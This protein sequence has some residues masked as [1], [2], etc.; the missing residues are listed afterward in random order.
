MS[1]LFCINR[2]I[3]LSAESFPWLKSSP[4]IKLLAA[5]CRGVLPCSSVAL[6]LI[7]PFSNMYTPIH[8]AVLKY[9]ISFLHFILVGHESSSLNPDVEV[10]LNIEANG[11]TLELA[12][13]RDNE[14]MVSLLA[15]R[16]IL[17]GVMR[18]S[19]L[20]LQIVLEVHIRALRALSL[21]SARNLFDIN[22]IYEEGDTVLHMAARSRNTDL[23][24]VLLNLGA[25]PDTRNEAGKTALD[26]MLDRP[27][28]NRSDEDKEIIRL[29]EETLETELATSPC[30]D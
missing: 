20:L 7:S 3:N 21:E 18:R 30:P 9:N 6:A 25:R 8:R 24:K 29:L 13:Q 15:P 2:Y 10:N 4:K 12:C 23:V 16:S 1:A 19:N 14:E 27:V 22:R 17:T 11:F 28:W 26:L 5:A